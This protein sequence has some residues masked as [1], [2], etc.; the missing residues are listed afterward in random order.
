MLLIMTNLSADHLSLNDRAATLDSKYRALIAYVPQDALLFSG[1]LMDILTYGNQACDSSRLEQFIRGLGIDAIS[2]K[3][4]NGLQSEIGE[5]G[6]FL[7]GGQCQRVAIARAILANRA[8]LIFD[9][10]T[11]ALDEASEAVVVDAI[12]S[13]CADRTRIFVSHR[14]QP[15]SRADR[16]LELRH[17]R[18]HEIANRPAPVITAR[19]QGNAVAA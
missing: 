9:E 5:S 1:T 6:K 15:V 13:L 19:P 11:S 8:I 3:L 4:P 2:E 18:L 16:V 10:A 17:G 14:E 12:H 7:S